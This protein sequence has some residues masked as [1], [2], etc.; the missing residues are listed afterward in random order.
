[1]VVKTDNVGNGIPYGMVIYGNA[2]MQGAAS[3]D[4]FNGTGADGYSVFGSDNITGG[5]SR[6]RIT[7]AYFNGLAKC[8]DILTI[9]NEAAG[10]ETIISANPSIIATFAT[11]SLTTSPDTLPNHDSTLCFGYTVSGGDN[12]RLLPAG[13]PN[14]QFQASDIHVMTLSPNPAEGN[15]PELVLKL[16]GSTESA[17]NVVITDMLGRRHYSGKASASGNGEY[18]IS[19]DKAKTGTYLVLIE[20]GPKVYKKML[21]VK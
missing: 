5:A 1:M 2:D 12:T 3:I 10:P 15:M 21:L 4:Q 18:R 16:D 8:E 17:V 6:L 14:D 11:T 7:K 19:L 9:P 13:K 20:A